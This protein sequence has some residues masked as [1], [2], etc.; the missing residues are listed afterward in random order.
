MAFYKSPEEFY[1][2]IEKG[3]AQ[4]GA[5]PKATEDFHK[6]HMVVDIRCTD[7]TVELMLDGRSN[8]I[9]TSFGPYDGKSDLKLELPTDLFHEILMGKASVKAAFMGGSVKVTGNVFR[10]LQLRD[11]FYQ[12][13]RLYPNILREMGYDV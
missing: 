12:I 13:S 10:A 8:P 6:R 9:K 3:F 2:V 4:L 1:A 11:L 5:D 7:P